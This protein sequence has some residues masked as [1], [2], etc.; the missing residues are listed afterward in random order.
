MVRRSDRADIKR[1]RANQNSKVD[2]DGRSSRSMGLPA[3]GVKSCIL[4][5][6]PGVALT[7]TPDA[8]ASAMTPV[9]FI[10][11]DT[12]GRLATPGL[13]PGSPAAPV[14]L[15]WRSAAANTSY[16]APLEHLQA[17]L[18]APGGAQNGV[19]RGFLC[20]S[21]R[22]RPAVTNRCESRPNEVVLFPV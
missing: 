2:A 15:L 3:C 1:Y 4:G 19:V 5:S 10:V 17:F 14:G 11:G 16:A 9:L 20:A 22:Y 8:A 21:L 6:S 13:A 18:A 12:V 7:G